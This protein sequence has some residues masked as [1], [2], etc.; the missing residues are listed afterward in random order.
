[1]LLS[2][3]TWLSVQALTQLRACGEQLIFMHA[4]FGE[5]IHFQ[6]FWVDAYMQY[7]AG[8]HTGLPNVVAMA[9]QVQDCGPPGGDK[10]R[11]G[12][13]AQQEIAPTC[14]R[15]ILFLKSPMG[16]Y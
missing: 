3:L 2:S 15:L 7:L 12:F 8:G 4:H 11:D 13:A 14:R 16:A 9:L 10:T 1:M 5:E 6:H